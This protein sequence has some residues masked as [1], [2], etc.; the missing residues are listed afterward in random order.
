MEVT[1]V[2]K[3]K[4]DKAVLA[5]ADMSAT[6]VQRKSRLALA[7]SEKTPP[8]MKTTP[9]HV[10]WLNPSSFTAVA[11]MAKMIATPPATI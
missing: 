5:M 7:S 1:V 10:P 9:P 3:T 2:E 6:V 4:M 8:R 11:A